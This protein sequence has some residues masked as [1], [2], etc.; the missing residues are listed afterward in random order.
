MDVIDTFVRGLNGQEELLTDCDLQQTESIGSADG[1]DKSIS[2][3]AYGTEN[4]YGFLLIQNEAVVIFDDEEYVI[5]K[6]TFKR[7]GNLTVATFDA[8][9]K[10]Y[11]DFNYDYIYDKYHEPDGNLKRDTMLSMIF[12]DSGYDYVFDSTGVD[13]TISSDSDWGDDYRIS[14]FNDFISKFSLEYKIVGTT[15]YLGKTV[16]QQTEFQMRYKYNAFDPSL[17]I[18][19]ENMYTYIKGF[20]HQY[21]DGTYAAQVEYT[22][23]LASVYGIRHAKPVVDD[24]AM[25]NDTLMAEVKKS[26]T[27]SM[28]ITITLTYEELQE[29]GVEDS[30]IGDY[31]FCI[32]DELDVDLEIRVSQIQRSNLKSESP[33]YTLGTLTQKAENILAEFDD[34]KQE[35]SK[36]ANETKTISST[37]KNVTTADGKLNLTK[38]EGILPASQV[39][40]GLANTLTDGLMSAGDFIKLSKIQV[41]TSGNVI[42]T[43]PLASSTENGLMSKEDF[44]KL[45]R[46]L[47]SG[48]G[49]V[50]LQTQVLDVLNNVLTQLQ[51]QE[52]MLQDHEN[53]ITALENGGGTGA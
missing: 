37:V 51:D 40:I 14:L 18:D 22:S 53:R 3:T 17:E 27:D 42:V 10:F 46:I 29:L 39:G 21:E 32:I 50:D 1:G 36:V 6:P 52:S 48:S 5:H 11:S 25:D 49:T 16:A 15:V 13:S 44:A 47:F 43:I 7:S 31:I 12:K 26:I 24:N 30:Q 9:H 35:V 2:V 34:T 45:G 28:N 23:P 41:D 38:S 8:Q 20:G 4:N 19:S 33:Q